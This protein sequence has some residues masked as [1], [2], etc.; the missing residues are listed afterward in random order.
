MTDLNNAAAALGRLLLSVIFLWSGFQK[1]A[2]FG[3][4]VGYMAS[5]GLP[6]PELAALVAIGV[7]CVGGILVLVGYQTRLVGLVM[8]GWWHRDGSRGACPFR[9]SEPDRASSEEPR[10]VGRFPPAGR[11]RRR[12][13]EPRCAGDGKHT[14][15]L[16]DPLGRQARGQLPCLR[17]ACLRLS[18]SSLGHKPNAR[19]P[20]RVRLQLVG[21]L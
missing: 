20:V 4:T 11:L 21:L 14:D 12:C 9:R 2:A 1:L 8:A 5:L 16:G 7:E 10:D 15:P 18:A 19:Q 6:V 3:G 13:V 17:R